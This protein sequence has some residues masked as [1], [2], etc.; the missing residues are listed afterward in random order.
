M[1]KR[2]LTASTPVPPPQL[3]KIVP[4]PRHRLPKLD[5]A[6]GILL[7]TDNYNLVTGFLRWFGPCSELQL[8]VRLMAFQGACAV[9]TFALRHALTG[10]YK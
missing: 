3:L 10:W 4:C 8:T 6:S 5:P 2:A 9:F 7:P 1:Q